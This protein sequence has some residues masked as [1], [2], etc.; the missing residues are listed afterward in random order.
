MLFLITCLC[1][2]A[3][4][5]ELAVQLQPG[6]HP[7]SWAERNH[8]RLVRPLSF[9]PDLY[10]F[11]SITDAPVAE[12]RARQ[13][14]ASSRDVLWAE[15][16]VRRPRRF[17]REIPDPLYDLQ[18]NIHAHPFSI[19][20]DHL[21]NL[22]GRGVTI[23]IVDDGLQYVHPEIHA[24]YD[25]AHSWD[26]ND[27]DPDPT[28]LGP[29][30]GHGTSA[31]GV[32]AAV[33]GNGHCGRGVAPH[34][35]LVG[36]RTIAEGV[37]DA[38]EAEALTHEGLGT[39]DIYSNSW[40]PADSGESMEGPGYVV[41]SALAA[42]A[43]ALRGRMGKGTI[44]LWA[45][46]NGA[47]KGDSC[48]YD[49]YASSPYVF[50]I[51][52]LDHQGN[53]ASY[54]EGCAA[55]MAVAPSSGAGRGITSADLLGEDG[56]TDSE[57]TIGFG[58]TSAAAPLAAGLIALLLEAQ[59]QL[60]WRDVMYVLA[61]G[62]L[63][64]HPE[65]GD[66]HVNAAGFHHSHRY[67]FGL[68]HGPSLLRALAGHTLLANRT[69]ALWRSGFKPLDDTWIG[70][71]NGTTVVLNV[72]SAAHIAVIER[73]TLSISLN[74]L[75]RGAISFSLQSP[76]GA[77]SHMA[78]GRRH[79]TTPFWPDGGWDFQSVRHLGERTANGVWRISA[80]DSGSESS[81]WVGYE[82][83]VRGGGA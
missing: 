19:D 9:L 80:R 81:H 62:A 37:S 65:D 12:S 2:V 76:E 75:N 56:Y 14:R 35:K 51:G 66:W 63:L 78:P 59:P 38:T 8:L 64:I 4:G 6:T 25:A 5:E 11:D 69:Q 36:L 70:G 28:P 3:L 29:H 53:A 44:Y 54:S 47:A 15:V 1:A 77:I 57:C 74:T 73:V 45:S 83:I 33:A 61:R 34:A 27:G 13:L 72:T 82:L 22:T 30:S 16:Q 58:G 49:G 7:L 46:G 20:A 52:A 24:N 41:Q 68:L 39:I 71:G 23:A 21:G 10:L 79:D 48:A 67:G 32:A 31:A 43:G 17:P 55:L 50:A 42:Y 60:S 40:G 18:W 26:Y